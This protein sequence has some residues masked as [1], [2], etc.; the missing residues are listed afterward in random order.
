MRLR[1]LSKRPSMSSKNRNDSPVS[2]P[3]WPGT[4]GTLRRFP[5]TLAK[6]AGY[7]KN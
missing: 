1:G 7:L 5:E 3:T 2:I 6:L 4:W